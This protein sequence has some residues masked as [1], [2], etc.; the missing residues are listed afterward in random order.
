MCNLE[1]AGWKPVPRGLADEGREE[2]E[3]RE[4]I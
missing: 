2:A 3:I 4:S 1:N